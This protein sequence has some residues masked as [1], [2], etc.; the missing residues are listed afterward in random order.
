M[1]ILSTSAPQV[2]IVVDADCRIGAGA[3]DKLART[4]FRT[5]RPVQACDLMVP[6]ASSDADYRIPAFAW[7]V[8]NL[9]RPLGLRALGLPCQLMGTG[10]AFPWPVIRQAELAS[11]HIVEDLKLG[12]EL[13]RAGYAPLFCP[14]VT[15]TSEFPSTMASADS[16]R[17]RWEGG[18]LSMAAKVA[19]PL[20]FK[21]IAHCNRELLALA[22]DMAVPP[23]TF[24]ALSAGGAFIVAGLAYIGGLSPVPLIISGATVG[25][26]FLTILLCWLNF[27]RDLLPI[28]ALAALGPFLVKKIRLYLGILTGKRTIQWTRTDRPLG[29]IET[30]KTQNRQPTSERDGVV[31]DAPYPRR[32]RLDQRLRHRVSDE[33]SKGS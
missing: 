28:G 4:A 16:Q 27:G 2:V 33:R 6:P 1:N 25:A 5:G 14:S 30:E 21:A 10:M 31:L 13:A 18:H 15:I 20:V 24:L 19:V 26:L 29:R 3:L 32:R 22:L 17:Q 9:M 23:I 11:G 7:R 12:L 8:K